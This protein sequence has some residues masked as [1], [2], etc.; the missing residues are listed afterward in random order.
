MLKPKFCYKDQKM[1]LGDV[2]IFAVTF[3]LNISLFFAGLF[4]DLN[5]DLD[6][7]IK[8]VTLILAIIFN[9]P[10]I[11]HFIDKILSM[12]RFRIKINKFKTNGKRFVAKIIDEDLGKP[13]M[14][15]ETYTIYTY[16]PV[17]KFC[18]SDFHKFILKSKYPMCASYKSALRSDTVTIY[19]M[20]EDFL[21]FDFE[22]TYSKNYT[23][24][25]R[26]SRNREIAD[27]NDRIYTKDQ[28]V[29]AISAL[30][31]ALIPVLLNIFCNIIFNL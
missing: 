22:E 26:T 15:F 13:L 16:Y 2:V 31:Y 12:I 27:M 11:A 23:L 18:D 7:L 9:I 25:R 30:I 19:V 17:V 28:I 20:N 3:I 24:K 4:Y 21:I 10:F 1:N 6:D 29:Y 14:K 5:G 8:L